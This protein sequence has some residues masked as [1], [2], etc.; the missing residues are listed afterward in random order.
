MEKGTNK[1]LFILLSVIIFGILL[2]ITYWFYYGNVKIILED[3]MFDSNQS[4]S[5]K[6]TDVFSDPPVVVASN[7]ETDFTF[8]PTT[9]TITGYVGVTKDVVIP[10]TIGGVPVEII[11][12][13]AFR[14]KE[15]TS[16]YIPEGVTDIEN[17]AFGINKITTL[18]LPKSLI[19][20][21]DYAFIANNLTTVDLP[22]NVISIG[23]E[24]FSTNQLTHVKI[25]PLV[26]VL[27]Q[28]VF[29]F[30]LLT[31]V[32]FHDN[33]KDI[34]HGAFYRNLLTNVT[35][36]NS[37]TYMGKTAFGKNNLISVDL[38]DNLTSLE[39]D[40]FINNKLTS[41]TIPETVTAIHR[42][43]LGGN[44]L[45][46]L[47]LPKNII[48]PNPATYNDLVICLNNPLV[49]VNVPLS[50]KT[51]I[52]ANNHILELTQG[53]SNLPSNIVYY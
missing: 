16:V 38:P 17:S 2:G 36:P 41:I 53:A 1:A 23:V 20:I 40:V 37:V 32:E 45:T 44:Q 13:E 9:G 47:T 6:L 30:N 25:P 14:F 12:T 4:I 7:P 46:T 21:G 35:L 26:T 34:G 11:G 33:L 8:E 48:I 52:Q 29:D 43:A 31:S 51:A 19:R 3:I 27:S 5:T 28:G 22:D 15:L 39:W 50:Q 18:T 24:A 10:S 49:T 42:A